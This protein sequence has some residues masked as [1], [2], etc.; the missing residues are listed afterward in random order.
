MKVSISYTDGIYEEYK[1]VESVGYPDPTSS[2]DWFV[3]HYK[4][5]VSR[6]YINGS[7]VKSFSA[8]TEI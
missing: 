6:T 7:F 8:R 2:D 1:N 4:E 3:L 5:G